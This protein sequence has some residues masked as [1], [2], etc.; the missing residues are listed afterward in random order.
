MQQ[1]KTAGNR[2]NGSM[3]ISDHVNISE[4]ENES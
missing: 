4:Y 1:A 2:R 3:E